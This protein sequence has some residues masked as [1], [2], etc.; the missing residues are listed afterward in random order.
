MEYRSF[1]WTVTGK[2][3]REAISLEHWIIENKKYHCACWLSRVR[4]YHGIAQCCYHNVVTQTH[5]MVIRYFAQPK[6]LFYAS[7]LISHSLCGAVSRG[8]PS[9]C[10]ALPSSG[11]YLQYVLITICSAGNLKKATS[12]DAISY[13]LG[14]GV[15]L[16]EDL[17]GHH[18][19]G[20]E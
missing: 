6:S 18:P 3:W 2:E 14:Y 8:I 11:Y 7:R 13:S 9:L 10:R 20:Y 19:N 5:T 12:F 1:E 16:C 17:V 4:Y 15:H